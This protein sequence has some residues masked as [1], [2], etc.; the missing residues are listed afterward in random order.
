MSA[1]KKV[2]IAIPPNKSTDVDFLPV[3]IKIKYT[4]IEAISPPKKENI[5]ITKRCIV[6]IA[7]DI[8]ITAPNAEPAE[9]PK[10]DGSANGFL[11]S[12]CITAPEIDNPIPTKND[13]SILGNLMS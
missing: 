10:I 7:N 9:T 4:N 11:K 3:E 2:P 12:P 8:G 6:W 5:G 13:K 1:F